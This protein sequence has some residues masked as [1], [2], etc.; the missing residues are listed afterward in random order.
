MNKSTNLLVTGMQ[1]L[2]TQVNACF[3]VFIFK[4]FCQS[5]CRRCMDGGH[6]FS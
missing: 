3:N 4:M 5:A 6:G 2:D 1:Q